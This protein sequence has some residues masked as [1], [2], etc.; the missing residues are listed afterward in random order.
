MVPKVIVD[1]DGLVTEVLG[2]H[3]RNHRFVGFSGLGGVGKTTL[4]KIIFNKVCAKFEFTCFVEEIKLIS[5]TKEEKK[6]KVWEKMCHH[7]RLYRVRVNLL[8]M[9]VA[10][11]KCEDIADLE[12][13]VWAKLKL[14]YDKLPSDEIKN[15]F[16]DIA[17]FFILDDYDF[18]PS[19]RPWRANDAM[20]AWSVTDRIA[21]NRVKLL[22]ERSLLKVSRSK[23]HEGFD[24][25]E[26]HLHEH[27][28]SMGQRIAQQEGRRYNL[29]RLS[30]QLDDYSYDDQ[31]ISQEGKELGKIVAHSI[32]IK[33]NLKRIFAQ[34]C[35]FC[36]MQQVW[37]KLTAIQYMTLT[38][39]ITNCCNQC[40]NQTVALP[41]T[42]LL[43]HLSLPHTDVVTGR[44][45]VD[46]MSGTLSLATCAS[47]VRLE[48]WNCKNLGDL[49]KLQQ[50][51]I[52]EIADCSVAGNWATS[53]GKLKSLERL[54]L[55]GIEEPFE[56]PISFGRLT[57]LQYLSISCHHG[58]QSLLFLPLSGT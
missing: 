10:L 24:Y 19:L 3:L 52:L 1:V 35:A 56:L 23:D 50:L 6:K 53:L 12:Q 18:R 48:L 5:G 45:S 21:Q 37:P 2:K 46:H 27:V 7:G 57:G 42:L 55:L 25:M 31:I 30:L 15:M 29:P 32:E 9:G 26:F 49:S 20:K 28:R 58:A 17:C 8:E 44:N 54:T 38:V 11:R 14:S 39:D 22:E 47:L 41:S 51:R 34:D 36:I 40:R 4:A 16:L 33:A 43:L 13:R